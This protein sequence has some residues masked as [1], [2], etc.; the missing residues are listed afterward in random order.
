MTFDMEEAL[1]D[2]RLSVLSNNRIAWE[3]VQKRIFKHIDRLLE[4]FGRTNKNT[5][6]TYT[7]EMLTADYSPNEVAM[8]VEEMISTSTGLPTV[9]DLKRYLRVKL[10]KKPAVKYNEEK[11]KQQSQAD[12]EAYLKL[13]KEY[14]TK[15]KWGDEEFKMW[16]K[17]YTREVF[18]EALLNCD[19]I[20]CFE[21]IALKDLAVANMDQ[22]R[23]IER[24]KKQAGLI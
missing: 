22:K 15:L 8:A 10:D 23:A 12:R 16:T 13:K 5:K 4:S 18:G 1:N 3:K 17:Y 7:Y 2:K 11:T 14:Q 19:Y 21:Q 6:D 9:G 20:G 24:G